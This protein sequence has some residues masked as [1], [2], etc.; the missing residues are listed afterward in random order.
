MR[1]DDFNWLLDHGTELQQKYAGKWIAVS[2]RRVVGVGDTAPEA[3]EQAMQSVAEGDYILEALDWDTDVID[4]YSGLRMEVAGQPTS[5]AN[6][7]ADGGS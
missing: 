6:V 4:A 7:A 2:G 1:T 5:R 3:E